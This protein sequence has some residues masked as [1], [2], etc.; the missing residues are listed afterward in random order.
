M[1]SVTWLILALIFLSSTGCLT[2]QTNKCP[3]QIVDR[4]GGGWG[5]DS[6]PKQ[7]PTD[8]LFDGLCEGLGEFFFDTLLGGLVDASY[9][10]YP[11]E[12]K[13]IGE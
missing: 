11:K 1:K 5:G 13:A 3:P 12:A 7:K 6:P 2:F 8:N 4:D 10:G 9:K